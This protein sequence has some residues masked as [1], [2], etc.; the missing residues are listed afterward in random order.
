MKTFILH[1]SLKKELIEIFCI[2]KITNLVNNKVYIGIT[3]RRPKIRFNEHFSNKKELLFKAKEK[4]RKENFSLEIIE[5]NLSEE[6]IDEK[7][8]YYIKFYNSLVPNGYNL[9]KGGMSNKSVSEDGKRKLKDCNLGINNPKCKKYILMIDIETKQVLNKFGS[10][11][12]AGRFL[13]NENKKTSILNCLK[14]K[15]ENT[16]GYIWKYEE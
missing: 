16:L 2:Y 13:G 8:R 11:R 15:C 4:Y 14:G 3:K 5:D 9:S 6:E 7:E 10:A 1:N 12:E